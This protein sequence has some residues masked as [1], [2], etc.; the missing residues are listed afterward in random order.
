VDRTYRTTLYMTTIGSDEHKLELEFRYSVT[1][2]SD[3][4]WDGQQWQPGWAAEADIRSAR[5]K[6]A[7]TEWVAMPE[8]MFGLFYADSNFQEELL[9]HAADQDEYARD[10]AADAKREEQMQ[11]R[12]R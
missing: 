7:P 4:Y 9:V 5:I 10:Q 8:W 3:D 12:G 1:P 11:E 6:V 2:G